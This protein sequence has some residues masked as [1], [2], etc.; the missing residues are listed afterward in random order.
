MNIMKNQRPQE[1]NEMGRLRWRRLDSIMNKRNNDA[2]KD[3]PSLNLVYD[4]QLPPAVPE[5]FQMLHAEVPQA[6]R[7]L[8]HTILVPHEV[9]MLC[10]VCKVRCIRSPTL[11]AVTAA[12]NT[13]ASPSTRGFEAKARHADGLH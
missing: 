10:Q 9:R 8:Y 2:C 7:M 3:L 11:G 4:R 1:K 5:R 13:C 12:K 6:G